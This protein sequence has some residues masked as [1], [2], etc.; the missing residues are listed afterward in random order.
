MGIH[1]EFDL[2]SVGRGEGK[3]ELD[4]ASPVG[5]EVGA[6][7]L[8]TAGCGQRHLHVAKARGEA[9]RWPDPLAVD[10][11]PDTIEQLD[12]RSP[13]ATHLAAGMK[14]HSRVATIFAAEIVSAVTRG[15]IAPLVELA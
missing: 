13:D 15:G 12:W 3:P 2:C 7:D 10:A 5:S 8:H 4:G 11:K 6:G 14:A 1:V 9:R